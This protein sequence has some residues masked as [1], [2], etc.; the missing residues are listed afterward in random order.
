MTLCAC[1]GACVRACVRACVIACVRA[2]EMS[3]NIHTKGN[4]W[5]IGQNISIAFERY[6]AQKE[7]LA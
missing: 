6:P 2:N 1:V 4:I 7:A 3:A 5:D